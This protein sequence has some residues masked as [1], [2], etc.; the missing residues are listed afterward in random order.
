MTNEEWWSDGIASVWRL[1]PCWQCLGYWPGTG[2][3]CPRSAPLC[4]RAGPERGRCRNSPGERG[5]EEHRW[6][7]PAR[8][9]RS[10]EET[11]SLGVEGMP[12]VGGEGQRCGREAS[13]GEYGLW[14]HLKGVLW[15][16]VSRE[17]IR[18]MLTGSKEAA[19]FDWSVPTEQDKGCIHN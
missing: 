1:S 4:P 16:V 6:D 11:W 13:I 2:G 5:G 8:T 17:R 14:R 9:R 19:D 3:W 7:M 18:V 12:R 15:E 10:G